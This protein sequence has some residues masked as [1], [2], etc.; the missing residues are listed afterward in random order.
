MDDRQTP[1]RSFFPAPFPTV[2]RPESWVTIFQHF[3][4]LKIHFSDSCGV[5][6]RVPCSPGTTFNVNLQVCVPTALQCSSPST[7]PICNCRESTVGTTCPGRSSCQ[8]NVCCQ[9]IGTTSIALQVQAAPPLCIGSGATPVSSCNQPCPNNYQCQPNIGCCP[10]STSQPIALCPGSGAIPLGSCVGSTSCPSGTHCNDQLGGCC[11][12]N[13]NIGKTFTAVIFCPGG[14]PASQPCGALNYCPDGQGCFQGACCPMVCPQGQSVQGFCNGN[15]CS[16]GSCVGGCCCQST[17]Q[18]PVC[19]NGQKAATSCILNSQCESGYECSNGGCCPRPYCPSGVQSYGHCMRGGCGSGQVCLDSLCCPMPRCNGGALAVRVCSVSSNC[20]PGF[21]C[22]NGGCCPLP[23]CPSGV[24]AS[25]RCSSGG[26]CCPRGQSCMNGG[27]C[28]MPRCPAG[29]IATGMCMSGYQCGRGNECINGGCCPMPRCP[30][31][32]QAVQRCQIGSTCP[33][34]QACEN[35]VCCPMPVCSYTGTVAMSMC[36]TR[37]ACP[38]GYLCEG[39][40]CCP[41]PMPLCPNGGRATQKCIRGSDC[42]PGFG[43][44]PLGGCCL[45]SLEP[46][47]PLRQNAICQCSPNS[48][49]PTQATCNMGTCCTSA[50][51]T[52]NMVPGSQC[53]AASQCN[54]F[55]SSCATC[56]RSVCVCTQG[57]Y[58]NGAACIPATALVLNRARNGCDQYGSPCRFHLSSARRKPL[59]APVGNNTENPLW[60]NVAG[61][62]FCVDNDT[63]ID[64]DSTCLPSE[65][66]I[67]GKCRM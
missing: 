39:R 40:G 24:T 52:Y 41:E 38:I 29:G 5:W 43:C 58:S 19:S 28:P 67:E 6:S 61:E 20:G 34:G 32:I 59:F 63:S 47:C 51:A 13:S 12:G 4:T 27:C 65:K 57:S 25:S 9:S 26:C 46:Q 45:L 14:S 50:V 8:Q 60:F 64:P 56:Q 3:S 7:A 44:T 11:P 36:G 31:G 1:D 2:F 62:R 17:P 35:G 49:C 30:S 18:L 54:G 53:Q 15:S 22:N 37:N 55:S 42:P 48:A 33:N 21:E 10:T 66:C 23:T 16:S